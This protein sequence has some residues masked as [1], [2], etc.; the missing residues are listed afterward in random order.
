M[1]LKEENF[2]QRVNNCYQYIH[3][4]SLE[5]GRYFLRIVIWD[6]VSGKVGYL[7]RT[8]EVPAL[9]KREFKL[10]EIVLARQIEVLPKKKSL[11][12]PSQEIPQLKMLSQVGLKVPANLS[13]TRRERGPFVFD[14]LRITP[15]PQRIYSP[16]DELL[17]FYQIYL[18]VVDHPEGQVRLTIEHQVLKGEEVIAQIDPSRQV[19]LP[20]REAQ[21]NLGLNQFTHFP[22]R[23]LAPGRYI[24][25]IKVRDENSGQVREKR[26]DFTVR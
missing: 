25:Q 16:Q 6:E 2:Q 9:R 24:L 12:I 3:A 13:L 17:F 5:S 22:L 15:N 10:S 8:L 14:N 19:T 21:I 23:Q 26:V 4:L 1:V 18:P 11:V 7:D 20:A